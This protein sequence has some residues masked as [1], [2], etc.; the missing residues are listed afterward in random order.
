MDKKLA[1]P[2]MLSYFGSLDQELTRCYGLA[3]TARQRGLD[4]EEEVNIPLANNMAERVVGLISVVAPQLAGTN[5]TARI[6]ELEKQYGMLDWR[7]GF[8]IAV[9]VA[10][11]KLA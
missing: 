9:E 7:V 10:K 1:S 6:Q 8:S 2:D 4:P 11:E 3:T 5:L